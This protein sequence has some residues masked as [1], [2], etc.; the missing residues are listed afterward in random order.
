MRRI[1]IGTTA[2]ALVAH[3]IGCAAD[4]PTA[5]KP[6]SGGKNNGALQIALFTSDAN[7]GAG[8]CSLLQAVATLNG[9][10][11]P[12]GTGIAFSTD[13]GFFSQNG[14]QTISVVTTG[15]AATTSVCSSSAGV[16]K[17]RA[18][19]SV[20]GKSGSA[21]LS[22]AFQ[23]SPSAG[24][25]DS[26]TPTFGNPAG[27]TALTLS[28]GRFTGTLGTTRV[29]FTAAGVSRE[30]LVTNVSPTQ[31]NLITPGFP[32]VSGVSSPVQIQ[33]FFGFGTP[34][35]T[36]LTAPNCFVFSTAPAGVPVVTAVLPSSGKNEGNTRVSIVGSGF[37]APL[38]VFFGT[39]EATV[40]SVSYNQVVALSPPAF[41]V[42]APNLNQTVD[43]R[44]REV[45]SGQEGTLSAG[46]RYT[47]AIQITAASN[48]TQ[49]GS[50][51]FTPVTIFGQ[52]FE[53]PVAVT[54]AGVAARVISVAATEL[55]VVPSAP[56]VASCA[57]ISGEIAVTNINTGDSTSSGS[58]LTFNY[59]VAAFGPVITSVSPASANVPST[60]LDITISGANLG[61]VSV[62]VGGK[63][64][65]ITSSSTGGNSITVHIPP[66]SAAAS[67]CGPSDTPGVTLLPVG[68]A[69]DVVVTDRGT[70]CSATFTGGFQYLLPCTP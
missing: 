69:I 38:Q 50:G 19:A 54:L 62:T 52:G 43:V 20:Q 64:A 2:L 60:G 59:L 55:V 7:P 48:T 29:L 46:F 24:F 18:S 41:G 22:I 8:A 39:V 32:E 34:S 28:G 68:G 12:D 1:T 70:T 3:L 21:G 26:C 36:T 13:L 31:I 44:V 66:S 35:P 65:A 25:V 17:V 10:N 30:A 42:G 51:P 5:P 11:V 47:P 53:A 16:A 4:A 15:G 40:Q 63:T 49:P 57:D 33:I 9:A 67:T 56:L 23:S 14:N 6:G 45:N 27:G 61:N 37:V 58:K